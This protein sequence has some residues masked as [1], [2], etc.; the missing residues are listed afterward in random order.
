MYWSPI[1]GSRQHIPFI[2]LQHG[3]VEHLGE[4]HQRQEIN[5]CQEAGAVHISSHGHLAVCPTEGETGKVPQTLCVC[6]VSKQQLLLLAVPNFL[7]VGMMGCIHHARS[8]EVLGY[9]VASLYQTP[10]IQRLHSVYPAMETAE[11]NLHDVLV[12]TWLRKA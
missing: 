9:I 12:R 3:L 10:G 2:Q 7:F 8:E 4:T 5:P 11:Q 1:G 6:S